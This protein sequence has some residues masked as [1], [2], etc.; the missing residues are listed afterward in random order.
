MHMTKLKFS[1]RSLYLI[2]LI[3]SGTNPFIS[4]QTLSPDLISSGGKHYQNAVGSISWSLGE[5]ATK[6]LVADGTILTQGFQ[7]NEYDIT[8]INEVSD[9]G[10]ELLVYPNPGE[11]MINISLKSEGGGWLTVELFD[12]SGYTLLL[13]HREIS[14]QTLNEPISIFGLP[15]GTYILKVNLNGSSNT[16]KIVKK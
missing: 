9:N 10:L 12:I 5:M 4:G 11:D 8:S 16:F 6:T 15:Q 3:G 7:Q 14:V 1:L 2:V 13:L